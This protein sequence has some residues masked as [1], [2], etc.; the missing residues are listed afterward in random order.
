MSFGK[1]VL[2]DSDTMLG[3]INPHTLTLELHCASRPGLEA[4]LRGDGDNTSAQVLAHELCHWTDLL[5]TVW[6]QS[7]LDVVFSAFDRVQSAADIVDTFP[8][9]LELYLTRTGRYYFRPI[10][11]WSAPLL[12]PPPTRS[13]G[14]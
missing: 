6:G 11:R 4:S 3:T 2:P 12:L 1:G 9:A 13:R 7:Y 8:H 10:T 14:H 5:G